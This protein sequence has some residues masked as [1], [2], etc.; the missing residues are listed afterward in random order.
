MSF[1][2]LL[3]SL[4]ILEAFSFDIIIAS[5]EKERKTKFRKWPSRLVSVDYHVLDLAAVA[6]RILKQRPN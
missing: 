1:H 6:M 3:F 2:S 5:K 4:G